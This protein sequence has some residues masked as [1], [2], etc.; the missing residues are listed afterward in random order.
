MTEKSG[1]G[2]AAILSAFVLIA[3]LT[4]TQ[5]ANAADTVLIPKIEGPWW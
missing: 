1:G 2:F 5:K 3:G 4:G